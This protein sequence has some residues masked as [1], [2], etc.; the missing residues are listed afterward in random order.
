MPKRLSRNELL[1]NTKEILNRSEDI[2]I[3]HLQC[4]NILLY[5]GIK[6][7]YNPISR[8]LKVMPH[9]MGEDP[10]SYTVSAVDFLKELLKLRP[11]G[12]RDVAMNILNAAP[13]VLEDK[14]PKEFSI[15][16]KS[17]PIDRPFE[18]AR[19]MRRI[20]IHISERANNLL[21]RLAKKKDTTLK[22]L[23]QTM[24]EM[25]VMDFYNKIEESLMEDFI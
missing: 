15:P 9:K 17:D 12:L 5:L 11:T 1:K 21:V 20:E 18:M 3:D 8:L 13:I 4:R 2:I 7:P 22:I 6:N 14:T 24:I 23:I 10:L 16:M 19:G 25:K